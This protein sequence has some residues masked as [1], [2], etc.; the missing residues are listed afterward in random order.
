VETDKPNDPVHIGSLGVNGVAVQTE[1]LA[2]LIEEFWVVTFWLKS[3]LP[4]PRKCETSSL[5]GRAAGK[6]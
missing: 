4:S 5:R 1:H 2:D 6:T 3:E